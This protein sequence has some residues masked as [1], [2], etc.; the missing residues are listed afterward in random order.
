MRRLKAPF[1]LSGLLI[2]VPALAQE[3]KPEDANQGQQPAAQ[4]PVAQAPVAQPAAAQPAAAQPAAAQPAAT[5]A[6]E[7]KPEAKEEKKK[8]ATTQ[9]LATF[10]GP[11]NVADE[12]WH[13]GY[14]GFFRA[15]MRFGLGSRTSLPGQSSMTMHSPLVPDD[16][17]LSWQHTSH[18]NKDWAE[19][20]FSYG[21]AWL[22]VSSAY[23]A[24]TSRI[25][26]RTSH[27][28]RTGLLWLGWSLR[29]TWV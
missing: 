13:F 4:A 24:T 5:Q 1:F 20:F 27:P 10:G 25:R 12:N 17:Y 6:T 3:V 9:E 15:P 16:Q 22:K 2:A 28:R 14:N 18:S 26:Q 19:L 11:A 8:A 23:R 7:A 21:N 29:Q